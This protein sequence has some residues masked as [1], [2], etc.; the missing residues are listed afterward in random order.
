MKLE[1]SK[2]WWM[3]QAREEGDA[4]VSAGSLRQVAAG[5]PDV[6]STGATKPTEE[7]NARSG[8]GGSSR[9]RSER[10]K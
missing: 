6:R 10:Q 7:K 5:T 3:A 2:E 8:T 1:R 4:V 9:P